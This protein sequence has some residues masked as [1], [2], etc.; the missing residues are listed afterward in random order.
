M[1]SLER[2]LWAGVG[3][4]M[5]WCRT[6]A[7]TQPCP[8]SFSALVMTTP[9]D[10]SLRC[11]VSAPLMAGARLTARILSVA[12]LAGVGVAVFRAVLDAK[13][14]RFVGAM[15]ALRDALLLTQ[16][17]PWLRDGRIQPSCAI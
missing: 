15:L 11:G 9:P 16:A 8:V 10:T 14:R 2:M 7:S 12:L 6:T 17:K 3:I 5:I 1:P 4:G 13:R